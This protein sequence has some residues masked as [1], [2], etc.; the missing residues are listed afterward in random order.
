MIEVKFDDA[1]TSIDQ[2]K[3]ADAKM[4]HDTANFKVKDEIYKKLPACCKYDWS[5]KEKE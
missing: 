1:K 2:I 3:K 4:G 5:E